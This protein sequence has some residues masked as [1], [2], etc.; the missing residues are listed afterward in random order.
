LKQ[1]IYLALGALTVIAIALIIPLISSSA[2]AAVFGSAPSIMVSSNSQF[3]TLPFGMLAFKMAVTATYSDDSVQTFYET[4]AM[5]GLALLAQPSTAQLIGLSAIGFVAL[6]LTQTSPADFKL[7]FTA[8]VPETDETVWNFTEIIAPP[9]NNMLAVA[10]TSPLAVPADM[11]YA[12]LGVSSHIVWMLSV[13][14][15][16]NN[17]NY[18]GAQTTVVTVG[19]DGTL[20]NLCTDCQLVLPQSLS[21]LG[22]L[23]SNQH[24][25]GPSASHQLASATAMRAREDYA[26]TQSLQTLA[27]YLESTSTSTTP[28]IPPAL[29]SALVTYLS[30]KS[31]SLTQE[32]LKLLAEALKS[33]GVQSEQISKQ[34]MIQAL[35][36]LDSSQITPQ[37]A[38]SLVKLLQSM[39]QNQIP[40]PIA[41]AADLAQFQIKSQQP[42][43]VNTVNNVVAVDSSGKIYMNNQVLA[44]NKFLRTSTGSVPG[45][46]VGGQ[47]RKL[48]VLPSD[49]TALTSYVE[50]QL[51]GSIVDLNMAAIL[52]IAAL[53]A[54]T[55]IAIATVIIA[56]SHQTH[57]RTRSRR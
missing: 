23:S 13:I 38:Q 7:N 14:A 49:S 12:N 40:I 51:G 34:M 22:P 24:L 44:V 8:T 1:K 33:Q 3:T 28:A 55:A 35:A 48:S 50:L 9:I 29:A 37:T 45:R 39:A 18:T 54:V 36:T 52:M 43:S 15:S 30:Q 5:P 41:L 47:L 32:Q 20:Q 2:W 42:Q 27:T 56:N 19:S 4:Q 11:I 16:A 57:R 46:R 26:K 10:V 25:L 21:L 31:N 6:N 17:L 53:V